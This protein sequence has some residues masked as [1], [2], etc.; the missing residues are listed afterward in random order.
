M[1]KISPWIRTFSRPNFLASA[2]VGRDNVA[3]VAAAL[4]ARSNCC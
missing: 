2:D 3:G 1:T 4:A